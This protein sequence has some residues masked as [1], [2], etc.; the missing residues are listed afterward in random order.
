MATSA[1]HVIACTL[2][3]A[4][5]EQQDYFS[6]FGLVPSCVVDLDDLRVRYRQL[7]QAVHPDRFAHECDRSQRLA[8]QQAAQV[9]A[10]Y[11]TL[12]SPLLRAQYLMARAGQERAAE[13]TVQDAGFLMTQIELRERLDEAANDLN[14]LDQLMVDV[15]QKIAQHQQ[16]FAE[17]W[18]KQEWLAAQNAIDKLQFATKL[19]LEIEDRQEHL[20]DI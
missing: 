13:R 8:Q 18:Q 7:Q 3:P 15:R 16:S 5:G 1:E 6:I 17:A 10:A 4:F 20:L 12:K 11:N 2:K 9:N 14:T 19:S